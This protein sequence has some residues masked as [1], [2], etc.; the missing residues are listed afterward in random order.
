MG[1]GRLTQ[2]NNSTYKW[3]VK[4]KRSPLRE[5]SPKKCDPGDSWWSFSWGPNSTRPGL[6]DVKMESSVMM[7][8]QGMAPAN[9]E[10]LLSSNEFTKNNSDTDPI[11]RQNV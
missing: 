7:L 6:Q 2:R 9:L 4:I 5:A 10:N 3:K 1:S 8:A 11:Q